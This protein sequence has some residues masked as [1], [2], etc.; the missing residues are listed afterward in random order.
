MN[1]RIRRLVLALLRMYW[2]VRRP[3]TIGARAVLVDGQ[4]KVLLV[5]HTYSSLWYLPGGGVEKGEGPAA[6]L[7]R[8]LREEVGVEAA[9]I[10]GLVGVY[11]S[12]REH[13]DDYVIVYC[14]TLTPEQAGCVRVC[15]P[16]IAEVGFF[17]PTQ[18]PEQTSPATR[19]RIAERFGGRSYADAW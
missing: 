1:S 9:V 15:S 3:R 4:G 13:K 14:V 17:A 8:E 7:L 12:R 5:R 2:W 16:E 19:R 11:H 10:D 6:G 18:L